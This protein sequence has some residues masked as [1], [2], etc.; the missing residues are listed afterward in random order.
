MLQFTIDQSALKAELGYIAGVVERKST[1]PVLSNIA[2][3]S[4][5][6]STLRL[7]G[8]DL[9]HTIVATLPA[10]I[11]QPGSLCINAAKLIDVVK[12]LE[13]GELSFAADDKNYM[14]LKAGKA[15]FRFAGVDRKEY[16]EPPQPKTMPFVLPAEV[17]NYMFTHVTFAI[18]NETSRFTLSGAKFSVGDGTVRAV[19]TDGHRLAFIEKK[20]DVKTTETLDMLVPKKALQQLTRLIAVGGP[21]IKFGQD[22]QHIFFESGTRVLCARKLTGN[23]PNYEMV[24]PKDNDKAVIFDWKPIK[25]AVRRVSL[26]VDQRNRSL[27]FT[28]RPGEVEVSAISSEEGEGSDFVPATYDGEETLLGFNFQYLLEF[29]NIVATGTEVEPAEGEEKESD[30]RLRFEFKD[31]QTATQIRIEGETGYDYRYVVMPLRL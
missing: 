23:F 1:I 9:D 31:S 30:L 2:V 25:A 14:N 22:P 5:D 24:M 6:D 8:T 19:S 16:P 26:M 27:R 12:N 28:I 11:S 17:L 29:F 20:A 10:K 3:E 13:P 18:T 7:V 15:K 4:I 21:E